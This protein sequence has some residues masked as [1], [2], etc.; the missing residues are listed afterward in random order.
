[1]AVIQSFGAL[2]RYGDSRSDA[3]AVARTAALDVMCGANYAAIYRSQPNVRTVVDFI[4]RNIA[5]VGFHV[6]RRVSDTDRVRLPDHQ[7]AQWLKDPNPDTTTFRLFEATMQD[8]GIHG[9]AYWMKVRQRATLGLVRMPPESVVPYGYLLPISYDWIKPDFTVKSLRASE[10]VAFRYFNP[11]DPLLGLSPLETLRQLLLE[12][13]AS[14][15]YRR[16][17][18]ANAARLEGV[19]TRPAGAP[20]WTPEQKQSWREQWAARYSGAP[21]QT[22]VLEDGMTFTPTT[23]SARDSEVTAARKLTREEVASAYHVPLPMVGILDHATFSNIREQ[24]KHLYQ[25]CLGPSFEM[26][27]QEIERQLLPECD[28]VDRVYIEANI[29]DKLKGSFEEQANAM[30]SAIGRPWM[31]ANEGR[32]RMNLPAQVNDPTADELALPLNM[33]APSLS[34]EPGPT[35]ADVAPAIRATWD[36]Q[37]A[38][39]D[40]LDPEDRATEFEMSRGRWDRELALDL[41]ARYRDAGLDEATAARKAMRLAAGINAETLQLLFARADAFTREAGM[42]V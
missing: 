14:H 31:T 30:R 13:S 37:R 29:A 19:V 32:A 38:R 28:D 15:A 21:G 12:D 10:V 3:P 34:D 35:A 41:A 40:K 42:Y 18:W 36:R 6:Y 2:Q 11:D 25:D 16:A 23:Y 9:R 8:L 4:A 27:Q 20:K 7:L 26:L 17:F 33:S 22:A 1:M 5:Q 24:H 39:L